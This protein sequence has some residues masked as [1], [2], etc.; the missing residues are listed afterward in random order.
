MYSGMSRNLRGAAVTTKASKRLWFLKKLKRAG[1]P[2][3]D[4]VNYYKA[5]IRPVMEYASPVWHSSLTS[6]Q[7]KTLEAVQRRACQI[8]IGGGTYI[9]QTS[10][11]CSS[12]KLDNLYTRRQ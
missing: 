3:S 5:V 1:E 11:N 2:Q 6:E 4:L 8:I 12:V 7:S 9:Q 10:S